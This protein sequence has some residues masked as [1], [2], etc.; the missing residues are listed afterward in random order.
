MAGSK[1][2]AT[3]TNCSKLCIYI[4][5]L[6]MESSVSHKMKHIDSGTIQTHA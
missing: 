3:D 6:Y 4:T 2:P 5:D 1:R